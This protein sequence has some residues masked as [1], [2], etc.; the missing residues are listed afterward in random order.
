VGWFEGGGRSLRLNAARWWLLSVGGP[1]KPALS[2]Y[3]WGGRKGR[4]DGPGAPRGLNSWLSIS[5]SNVRDA[6][7]AMSVF[8]IVHQDDV[9]GKL[10]CFERLIFKGQCVSWGCITLV[11]WQPSWSLRA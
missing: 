10:T 5:E 8:E 1:A 3:A 6:T 7:G 2:A 11:G 4:R 9:V